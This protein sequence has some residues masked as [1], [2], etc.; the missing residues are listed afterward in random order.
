MLKNQW[1]VAKRMIKF[2]HSTFTFPQ[3]N[4]WT[5]IK[6]NQVDELVLFITE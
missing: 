4:K 5:F 6:I 1:L 3:K 2:T